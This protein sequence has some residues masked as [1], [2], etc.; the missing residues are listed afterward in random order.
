[1]ALDVIL[2]LDIPQ[3]SR[4][5]STTEKTLRA[6]LKRRVMGLAVLERT[7]KRQ[8]SRITNLRVG[9]A[10]TKYFHM[11]MNSRCRKNHIQKLQHNGGW[12]TSHEDKAKL[13]FDHFS[14][15]LGRPPLRQMDLNW[16]EINPA[17][18]DLEDLALPFSIDEIKT[19]IESMPAD[20]AP[21]PDGYTMAFFTSCW[22]IINPDLMRVMDAFSELSVNNFHVLNSANVAL[23]PKKE[24]SESI[25]DFHPISLIHIIPKII[26]K[27][28]ATRL[29]PRMND[30]VSHCQ[31]AF[32]KA[33]SIH[34]NFMYVRNTARRLHRNHSPTLLLK[35]DIA[36][37]FDSMRWDYLLDIM[38]RKGFPP[39]WRAWMVILFTMASS[40]VLLNGIA[41]LDIMHGR[42][43]RQGDPL[44]P[45]SL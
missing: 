30:I 14:Q 26:A 8:A 34:D 12:V 32:I 11:R 7:R 41:G 16:A 5:L 35:L 20:K 36:K 33:R 18:H 28:M 13:I 4:T 15:T 27:A 17:A 44:S 6:A 22:D 1:M 24:G 10:N 40:R 42:G 23:L 29:A 37:A 45:S 19:A 43:L 38:Q 21:G 39:R 25:A 31:S 3:D 2:Q 9:D